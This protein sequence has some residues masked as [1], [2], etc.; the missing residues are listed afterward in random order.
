MSGFPLHM[1]TTYG[2][3]M[4]WKCERC[5]KRWVDGYLMECHHRKP[6]SSG[7]KDTY[8]NMEMLCLWCHH[9][10]H[11]ALLEKGL[12]DFRSPGII[13]RRLQRTKGLRDGFTIR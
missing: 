1:R 7:G 8:D 11:V 3:K 5:G 10:A 9:H 2:K 12:G 4:G 13:E 6:T